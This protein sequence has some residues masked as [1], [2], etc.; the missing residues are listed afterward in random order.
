MTEAVMS[1]PA[2]PS[3]ASLP[4]NGSLAAI[5][6]QRAQST[7]NPTTTTTV[8]NAPEDPTSS[9]SSPFSF[10]AVDPQQRPLNSQEAMILTCLNFL[11]IVY[12]E[13]WGGGGVRTERNN[14]HP[15]LQWHWQLY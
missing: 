2:A 15:N 4:I 6:L 11:T 13:G 14:H 9:Y 10:K 3:R 5:R 12:K 7:S 1:Q 8:G